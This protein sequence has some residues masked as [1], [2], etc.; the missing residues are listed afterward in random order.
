V[1]GRIS[2]IVDFSSPKSREFSRISSLRLV[3]N[4]FNRQ[5]YF[6]DWEPQ[7]GR[8]SYADILV[9]YASAY[10]GFF[11]INIVLIQF[12]VKA[13]AEYGKT[14][15]P[16]IAVWTKENPG[17]AWIQMVFHLIAIPFCVFIIAAFRNIHDCI[18]VSRSVFI[19]GFY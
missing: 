11:V 4:Q 12:L 2:S 10:H 7:K 3:Q 1:R 8:I 15:T 14:D 5:N 18:L 19:F 17:A 9:T 16:Q 13:L 6:Y